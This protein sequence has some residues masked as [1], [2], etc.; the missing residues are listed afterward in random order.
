[1]TDAT[2]Q[3]ATATRRD[4]ALTVAE[5]AARLGISAGAVRKRVERG[6]LRADKGPGGQWRVLLDSNSPDL[7]QTASIPNRNATPRQD[8]TRPQ[9]R[10]D[11][12]GAT[13]A[14]PDTF[15]VPGSSDAALVEQLRSEV[16]HLRDTLARSQA[17]EAELRRLLAAEH[18]P[19]RLAAP[20]E[21]PP[22]DGRDFDPPP[23]VA[24]VPAVPGPARRPWW[25]R[26]GGQER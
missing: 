9:G 4:G 16:A 26:W 21:N 18:E 19:K 13:E 12:T 6:Q 11:T 22:P 23:G 17:G 3:D 5:A 10:R 25:R 20:T 15:P 7:P 8:A 1:M 2:G 14:E 24:G